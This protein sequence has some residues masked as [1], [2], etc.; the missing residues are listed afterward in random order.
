MCVYVCIT[1]RRS[2]SLNCNQS[3]CFQRWPGTVVSF[4]CEERQGDFLLKVDFEGFCVE[5]GKLLEPLVL[6]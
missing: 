2:F 1:E 4:G 3:R 5:A 6:C